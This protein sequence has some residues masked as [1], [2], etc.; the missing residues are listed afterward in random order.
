MDS[1][2]LVELFDR[3]VDGICSD[4]DAARLR[5]ALLESAE[6]RRAY[7][8]EMY[9]H[10]FIGELLREKRGVSM[11]VGEKRAWRRGG[12]RRSWMLV[13]AG[14][15]AMLLVAVGIRPFLSGPRVAEGKAGSLLAASALHHEGQQL[16]YGQVVR[17]LWEKPLEVQLADESRLSLCEESAVSVPKR[18]RVELRSGGVRVAVRRDEKD[19]FVVS[20]GDASVRALGTEFVVLTGG[21]AAEEDEMAGSRLVS[22]VVISGAVL[23]SNPLGELKLSAGEAGVSRD[24]AAPAPTGIAERVRRLIALLANDDYQ[25][26]EK[27]FKELT[28]LADRHGAIVVPLC[29]A[30]RKATKDPEVRERLKAFKDPG[31]RRGPREILLPEPGENGEVAELRPPGWR[32]PVGSGIKGGVNC[33]GKVAAMQAL[34]DAVLPGFIQGHS[35]GLLGCADVDGDGSRE[36]LVYRGKKGPT[37]LHAFKA[38]GGQAEGFPREMKRAVPGGT[39][40]DINGDG[41]VE[42]VSLNG[43][44]VEVCDLEGEP[45]KGFPVKFGGGLYKSLAVEDLTGNGRKEIVVSRWMQREIKAWDSSGKMLPGYPVKLPAWKQ[46]VMYTMT[47]A[48][49][50]KGYKRAHVLTLHGGAGL[51]M[52]DGAGRF[53]RGW[54][55][56]LEKAGLV[57][58]YG[59]GGKACGDV[60]GDGIDEVFALVG[61]QQ[62]GRDWQLLALDRSGKPLAGY[63]RPWS[64]V[65]GA[66]A[67][68]GGQDLA[69]GLKID[70]G[71]VDGD[72]KQE[73]VWVDIAAYIHVAKA[74]GTEL[75]GFPKPMRHGNYQ[76]PITRPV[77]WDCDGDRKA[78]IFYLVYGAQGEGYTLQVLGADGEDRAKELGY[79]LT[80]SGY[81]VQSLR[82]EHLKKGNG[83]SLVMWARPRSKGRDL[84][85]WHTR[86]VMG[87]TLKASKRR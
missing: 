15:A 73:A 22:V 67:G 76:A 20:A 85:K 21:R 71:D 69:R 59:G 77:V 65:G 52:L 86:Q 72:G 17:T 1:A 25:T 49:L 87:F 32:P 28:E 78:E 16:E 10:A 75:D 26:R 79:D 70:F 12:L 80:I 11:A 46:N 34:N 57:F 8:T 37:T 42:I 51:T 50:D 61:K 44:S 33:G 27:A 18:R 66:A 60:T 43:D 31:A 30:A 74:D 84:Q 13:A 45:L 55:V 39:A 5:D 63:P 3:V 54:P 6:A 19:P 35:Y 4:S 64:V 82:V 14:A 7:W 38:S 47:S 62:G 53:A 68:F 56:S 2:R 23:L 48:R 58:S 40:G 41:K 29:E 9:R 81:T 24:G 83:P 36:V